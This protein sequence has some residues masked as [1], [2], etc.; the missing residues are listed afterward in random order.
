MCGI[1]AFSGKEEALP[2]LLQGLHKLEYRGYDSAGVTLV[3]KDKLFTIKAKGRLQNLVDRLDQAVPSG[4]VGIGHTRWATHGVPSNLN[5]HPHTNNDNTIS[6]VHNGIIENYRELKEKLIAKGY[7]FHSETDSEVVVHLLDSYYQGDML[8]ALRKVID[9]IEGSY[10]L[11]IVSTLEPDTIYVTKKDSPLVLGINDEA[12]FGAS[13]IPALLDY[14]K[15]VYFIEDY[16]IAKLCK[17]KITFYDH[18]GNTINKKTTHIPYDNEAAQ[19]GGY[20]TFMLKEIHE[21]PYAIS[22]T[23]RG[24]VEGEDQIILPELDSLKDRFATFNNVYFVACGTA[25]HACLSGAN[26]LERLTGIPT[27]TQ[28]ASEFRYGDPIIDE[29]TLCIF[30]SQSGETADTMAALRL[31]KEKKATTLAIANVLGSSISREAKATIYTC[32]GPE[33]AVASTKA[34]TTQVIVLLLLAIYIAQSLGK[35]DEIYKDL[36]KGIAKLPQQIEDILKD[37][38][39]FENYANYL[40]DQHDAY[41]IGRS[42]DYASVLEGALKLKEVSYIHADAYIAGELK[43]G[44]I[45][46]IENGSVVIAVATQPHIAAKTIS[47]IQETIARGAKVILF[48]LEGEEVGNV[49]ETYYMP[50]VNPILQAVLVAIPLQLIGYY[51]A[52]IKGCDVDKPR[53]LAKSVTVE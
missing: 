37:E 32:A 24:R 29:K 2:F 39:I 48:T 43:H 34:Y 6:L 22:E 42:L 44:P 33:I 7:T 8:E 23:L 4:C 28:A 10:A 17:N 5:S 12:S 36:I 18:Q 19:K 49:N 51:A 15:D 13:D 14:T 50:N 25:Y 41:Y 11:C 47:N 30:V 27:F 3:D 46:L 35:E 53:N 9:R 20:D 52:K 26:I 16:E 38:K 40:K 21:Q 1:T 45:A 31:A